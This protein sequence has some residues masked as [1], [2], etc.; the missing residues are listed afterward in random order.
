MPMSDADIFADDDEKPISFRGATTPANAN[1]KRDLHGGI[2]LADPA[3]E[4][5]EI[6]R[7]I[8]KTSM[9][10]A[11]AYDILF[12]RKKQADKVARERDREE[13]ARS[14]GLTITNKK[15]GPIGWRKR[16]LLL[17]AMFGGRKE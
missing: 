16:L 12:E 11:M 5:R 10:G 9:D 1:G 14:V 17:M 2:Q 13:K 7:E 3:A 4:P 15:K 8:V 6:N